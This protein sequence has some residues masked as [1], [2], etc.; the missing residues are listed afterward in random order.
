MSE[1]YA[2]SVGV[3]SP[4]PA[5]VSRPRVH[6]ENP[7]W[8]RHSCRL[9]PYLFYLFPLPTSISAH[10][11]AAITKTHSEFASEFALQKRHSAP[12]SRRLK[13]SSSGRLARSNGQQRSGVQ[14]WARCPYDEQPASLSLHNLR[15]HSFRR[16]FV[17]SLLFFVTFVSA[18][19]V[20]VLASLTENLLNNLHLQLMRS[21]PV[22]D[23]ASPKEPRVTRKPIPQRP[24]RPMK[25]RPSPSRL[26]R[27]PNFSPKPFLC[28]LG[29]LRGG[30]FRCSRRSWLLGALAVKKSG[31]EGSQLRLHLPPHRFRMNTINQPSQ[32]SP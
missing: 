9:D 17:L 4:A 14:V 18:V 2:A 3:G 29:V 24:S 13:K 21:H 5:V 11:S 30:S 8:R 16:P 22:A 12:A 26:E 6:L 15:L 32:K 20:A 19:P 1:P 10:N 31:N 28:A 27:I 7:R 25:L 23:Q